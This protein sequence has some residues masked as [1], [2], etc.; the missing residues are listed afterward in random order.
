M[1]NWKTMIKH[2]MKDHEKLVQKMTSSH[3]CHF[4]WSHLCLLK[5]VIAF[6]FQIAIEDL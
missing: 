2:S 6:V 3:V 4:D 1:K 5:D